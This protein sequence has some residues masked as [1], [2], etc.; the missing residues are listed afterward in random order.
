LD[1]NRSHDLSRL[2]IAWI[3]ALCQRNLDID[4]I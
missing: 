4:N 1:I 2:A 3:A